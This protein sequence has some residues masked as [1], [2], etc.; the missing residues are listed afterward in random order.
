VKCKQLLGGWRQLPRTPRV[1]PLCAGVSPGTRLSVVAFCAVSSA[2][3]LSGAFVAT[4]GSAI[5]AIELSVFNLVNEA[6]VKGAGYE[7]NRVPGA[8]G[9]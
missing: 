5:F 6:G 8:R 2:A 9:G 4:S 1:G 7:D 3:S